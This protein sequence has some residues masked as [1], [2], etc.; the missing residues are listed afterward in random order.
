MSTM[1]KRVI[2]TV[3]RLYEPLTKQY[4]KKQYA[5]SLPLTMPESG[6]VLVLAPHVDD[7]TIG[8]GGTILAHKENG[9]AVTVLYLTDGSGSMS[10]SVGAELADIRKEEAKQ[11]KAI[12]ELDEIHFLDAKDGQLQKATESEA[13]Q[14]TFQEHV[15]QIDPDVIY[16]P[17]MIDCHPDHVATGELLLGLTGERKVRLYEINTA[18]PPHRLNCVVDVSGHQRQKEKAIDLFTSQAIDF[19]G[20]LNLSA[21]KSALLGKEAAVTHVETFLEMPLAQFQ[22]RYPILQKKGICYADYLKQMNKTATLP[23]ALAK[24]RKLKDGWYESVT[25][26]GEG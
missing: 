20:F 12:L 26:G 1:K 7:E 15:E 14:Q 6:R 11:V 17:T 24:N 22:A 3:G 13:F 21:W 2:T 8:A 4:V 16:L 9:A 5:Q 18:I 19:D 23:L 10:Q 25:G